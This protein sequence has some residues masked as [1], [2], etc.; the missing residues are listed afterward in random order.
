MREN[1]GEVFGGTTTARMGTLMTDTPI[2]STDGS[3][4]ASWVTVSDAAETA[5]VD[6]RTVRHWYRTGRLPT[7]RAEGTSGA[8]LVP[9]DE[10]LVLAGQLADE[11][12]E[13]SAHRSGLDASYWAMQAEAARQEAVKAREESA[14][15]KA[16][17][18]E[19]VEQ[20]AFLRTQLA[21]LSEENRN[22]REQL[23]NSTAAVAMANSDADRLRDE[24]AG[25]SSITDYSWLDRTRAYESPVRPQQRLGT[26]GIS[27]LL[28]SVQPDAGASSNGEGARVGPAS[29]VQRT[30]TGALPHPTE[31]DDGPDFSDLDPVRATAATEPT[32]P[33]H[34]YGTYED[35]LLPEPDKRGRRR[36]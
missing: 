26:G 34:S 28:A 22:L 24:A 14:E 27:G 31:D 19:T 4:A 18:Q 13:E 3:S 17:I 32:V 33:D 2:A 6:T 5:R 21:E 35:D 11:Q 25:T 23:E 29:I 1:V 30:P 8:F 36:G 15:T 16:S 10:V 12:D 9:L 20:M 7:H